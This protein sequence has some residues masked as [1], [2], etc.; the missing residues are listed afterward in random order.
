MCQIFLDQKKGQSNQQNFEQ[1]MELFS[2]A[3]LNKMLS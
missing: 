3:E 1:R 2:N